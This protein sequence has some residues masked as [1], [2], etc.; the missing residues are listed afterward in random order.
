MA[1]T[2]KGHIYSMNRAFYHD[3][4]VTHTPMFPFAQAASQEA[5]R[6]SESGQW[7]CAVALLTVA[8]QAL[9][10]TKLQHLRQRAACLAQLGLNKQAVSDL[11]RVIL[12]HSQDSSEEAKVKAEDLCRRGQNLLTFSWDE[13]ALNDFSQALELHA[14]QTLLCVEAGPGRHRLAELFLRFA[15]QNYGEQQLD[16]AWRLTES[17]LR[18]DSNHAELRRLKARIKREVSGT[19]IVH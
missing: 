14:E 2:L 8:V 15:L 9:D 1:I 13:V 11:D 4:Q 3:V 6:V 19:C 7:E 5:S 10:G 17:G 12:S 16:K 18:V